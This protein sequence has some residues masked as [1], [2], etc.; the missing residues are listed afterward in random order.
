METAVRHRPFEFLESTFRDPPRVERRAAPASQSRAPGPCMEFF[1][2]CGVRGFSRIP[3]AFQVFARIFLYFRGFFLDTT[4]MPTGD[5]KW[6]EE[7]RSKV[8]P[9]GDA[10]YESESD[11]HGNRSPDYV[12]AS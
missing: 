12:K 1:V 4:Q 2:T 8:E 11:S 7:K 3:A 6:L 5:P 9:Q 10:I